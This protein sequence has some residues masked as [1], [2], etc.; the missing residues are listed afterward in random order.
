MM[1]IPKRTMSSSKRVLFLTL[2]VAPLVDPLGAGG[3]AGV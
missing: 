1:Y 2:L 3:G